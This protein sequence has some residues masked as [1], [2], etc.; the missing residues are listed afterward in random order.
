MFSADINT[1]KQKHINTFLSN[2]FGKIDRF[3]ENN[4][5]VPNRKM[6][7]PSARNER[8]YPFFRQR[9]KTNQKQLE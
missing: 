6:R 8:Y 9:L 7:H 3:F 5:P 4:T 2:S 1:L